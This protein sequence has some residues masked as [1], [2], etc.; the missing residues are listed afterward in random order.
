MTLDEI[1][2][3]FQAAVQSGALGGD[4]PPGLAA[5]LA[6]LGI[7]GPLPL[8][9]GGTG[10][11][12]AEAWLTATT[13]YLRPGWRWRLRLTGSLREDADQADLVLE[14]VFDAGTGPWTFG[15]AFGTLPISRV[16]ADD[17]GG[18]VAG[19]SV[20]AHLV[21]EQPVV[22]ATNSPRAA[23]RLTGTLPLR[24]DAGVPGSDLLSGYADLLGDR[25][26]ADGTVDLPAA[27]PVVLEL[28]ATAPGVG[29][30]IDRPAVDAVGLALTTTF[31]DPAPLHEPHAVLS[32]VLLFA[33]VALPT[34]P[35]DVV[36]V[37]GPLLT[38][39]HLWP[40][41]L[42]FATP[43]GLVGG[44][45]ALT[46]I[47]GGG[48]GDFELPAG[49]AAVDAF[50]L[51]FMELGI[52]PPGR[53]GPGL[54]YVTAGI[55]SDE[56]WDPPVPY[57][58]I[59]R[60]GVGWGFSFGGGGAPFVWG[61]LFGTMTFGRKTAPSLGAAPSYQERAARGLLP[62]AP[63]LPDV[64]VT[65]ELSLPDLWFTAYTEGPIEVGFSQILA[66]LL[67]EA[68]RTGADLTIESLSIEGSLPQKSLG[69]AL[70]VVGDWSLTIGEVILTLAGFGFQVEISQSGVS[71]L[72]RGVGTLTV[73]GADPP[74]PP[75]ELYVEARY[76]GG[77]A[78]V[79]A[80]GARGSV[81]V[82]GLVRG[83]LGRAPDWLRD[84]RYVDVELADLGILFSTASGHPFS[85]SGTL[86]VG[87]P[88]QLLGLAVRLLLSVDIERRLSTASADEH[89]A[90]VA[91]G[92]PAA[93]SG[94]LV[95]GSL[96]G[97]FSVGG[98]VVA[99]SVSVT[100]AEKDFTFAVTYRDVSLRA[101]TSWITSPAPRHEILT[102]TLT[103]TLGELLAYLVALVNPNA[104]FRLDP[105]WDFLGSLDLTGISVV[106]DPTA[107]SVAAVWK[108]KLDLGFVTIESVGV[109]YDH[110]S[111]KPG[112]RIELSARMAGDTVA[113]PR[114][115]DPVNQAPPQ[116]PGLGDRL[117]SLRYLGLGQHVTPAA[118]TTY[119][120]IS[121]VV[122]ALASAMRPVDPVP[123]PP[124]VGAGTPMRFDAS[125]Q[126]L[127]GLDLTVMDTVAVKLVM[128]DPDLY[129]VL[130][131]LSGPQAGPLA[132]LRAEL[133]YRKVADGIGVFH[134]RLQVP[135]ALRHMEFG[136]VSVT[137]GLITVDIY[138]N[139]DFRIDL[140]F[141]SG[142]DFSSSFAVEAGLYNGRGGLYFGVLSGATS[143]RVPAVTDGTFSPVVELGIGLSVGVGRT[144]ERGPLRAG[145]YANLVLI[146]E[147]V[148]AWFH[149]ADGDGDTDLYYWC[150]GTVGIVGR[151]FASVDF[152]II[153][154]EISV[155]VAAMATVELEAYRAAV[156]SLSV[157]LRASAS[158]RIAF[159]TI[160]FSF[161]LSLQ[162]SFTIGADSVPPWHVASGAP[163][164]RLPASVRAEVAP[165][166]GYRLRFDPDARVFP[167]G[168]P[169]TVSLTLVPGYT[170]AG[171]PA[172]WTGQTVPP[173]GDPGY[174]LV[175]TLV[176]DNAVP[177]DAMTI[178]RALRPDVTRNA[179]ADTPADASFN[180]LAE[181]LLRWA[182]D[183]L[184]V[185]G[186]DSVVSLAQLSDLVQQLAMPEAA[187]SGFTW[188]A[189][190][191]FLTA[192]LHL[193]VSGTQ[194]AGGSDPVPGTPFPMLPVLTWT[195]TGLPDPGDA[196]RDFA[197]HQPVD[198]TYEADVLGY[199][200]DL[201]P[202][203]R[204]DA[205]APAARSVAT[206][207][208]SESMATYV[209]RDYFHLVTRAAAQAAVD[210]LTAY[211]YSV[212]GQ[213]SLRSVAA[214]FPAASAALRVA[215]GDT[216]ESV[217]SRLRVTPSE[218]AAH[219]PRLPDELAA[220]R[221]GDGLAVAVAVTPESI[222]LANPDWP[223]TEGSRVNLGDL[224]VQS[225][226]RTLSQLVRDYRL[227][228][229]ADPGYRAA[230]TALTGH[231][232]ATT[233]LLRAGATV[234]VAGLTVRSDAQ[235]DRVAAAFWV[236]LGHVQPLDVPRAD[237]YQQAI[238]RLNPGVPEQVPLDTALDVPTRYEST[239]SS[240][241]APLEGDTLLL[242]AACAAL[243]QEPALDPSFASWL[244][245][246]RAANAP[247]PPGAVVLPAGATAVV[248]PQDTL[249]SLRE[250]LL[251]GPDDFAGY[252]ADADVLLPLVTAEVP[253]AVGE[254]GP[255]LTLLTLGQRYGL[256]LG[257]LAARIAD[258]TGVL[259]PVA[260][261][262]LVVPD[263]PAVPLADLVAAL[264][265]GPAMGSVSGQAARFLLGGLC[266]P[267]PV[268]EGGVYR[269]RG[270]VTGL[271]ELIGQQVT[272][273]P[274]P[275]QP[276]TAAEPP[277]VTV[278]VTKVGPADWL[279]F[280]PP[281]TG[282]A[283]AVGE[284]PSTAVVTVT[285]ADLRDHYPATG[286]Q[287][288]V[289]AP[290]APVPLRHDAAVR[291]PVTQV[292]AWHTTAKVV[293]PAEAAAPPT[294]W[295][296]PA[297]LVARA[298]ADSAGP[299]VLLEQTAPQAA[300]GAPYRELDAY[301]WAALSSFTV[302]RIPGTPGTVEVLGA[303]AAERR[304]IAELLSYLRGSGD[305]AHPLTVAWRLPA[306]PGRTATGLTS[307]PL[308]TDR[309]FVARTN[310]STRTA[311]G[312]AASA[313]TA[314]RN[315]AT[316]GDAEAFLALLWE[317]STVGG[318]GYWM[319]FGG[320]VPDAAFDQDG[321]AEL[322]LVVQ[323]ASQAELR[324]HPFMNAAVVGDGI[325]PATVALTARAAEP[326]P[327]DVR[328]AASA[329][330]G[331][332][333][334]RARFG[335]PLADD[336]PQG[337]LRRLYGLLSFSLGAT[338]AF[339]GSGESRPVSPRPA[340]D[341]DEL[342]LLTACEEAEPVWELSRIVDSGRFARSR[343]PDVPT[344]PPSEGDPY[345]G[346]AARSGIPVLARFGD[347]FGN[348]S[349]TVGTVTLPVRYTDPVV[350]V[351]GWPSTTL[352]YGV[353]AAAD[354]AVLT[355]S[356]DFQAVAYQ[357]GPSGTAAD[358]ATAAATGREQLVSVHHQLAQPDIAVSVLTSLQQAP[359]SD[360]V[361]LAVDADV[362]RRYAIGAHAL[363]DSLTAVLPLPATAAPTLDG[364]CAAYG[365][366]HDALAAANAATPLD[367][368]V[369]A[370]EMAV[371]VTG[372]FHAGETVTAVCARL[373]PPLDA[374][375]VLLDQD[376][377]VLP[378]ATGAELG[379]P[380]H[381]V[382]VPLG[383]P[384][385]G[386][387]AAQCGCS[388]A[389]LVAAN[390]DRA[391]LLTPGFTFEC[392]GLRVGIATDPPQSEATLAGVAL[393]FQQ[394][395]VPFDVQQIVA[396]NS[397]SPG[398]F[399]SGAAVDVDGYL[400]AAGDTLAVNGAGR[401][402]EDLAPLNTTTADL[403][404]P[405]TP[406]FLTVRSAPLTAGET[407]AEFA[408][409]RG[410]T[411]GALLRHNG[412]LTVPPATP[413]VVPGRWQWPE[414]PEE[415]VRVPCTVQPGDSLD[416][417]AGRCPGADLVTVNATMPKTVAP[418]VT[419]TVDG[420]SATTA[421][422]SSF[423]EVCA[424]FDPPADLAALQA[425]IGARTDVLA[426]G[427][428]L[429][430]PPGV[431]PTATPGL[432]GTTPGDAARPFGV[433]AVALLAAN[434][435]APDVLLPGQVL[436][437]PAQPDGSVPTQTTTESDT[438]TAVV[439]RF[440]RQGA[441]VAVET[442]V[443]AN[444]GIGFLRPGA[445]VL[446]PP[447]GARLRV[448]L[449]ES[450]PGA[451]GRP[452]PA[453]VFPV[454]VALDISRDP[455]LVDPD[456]AGSATRNTTAVAPDWAA[457]D[458][459]GTRGLADFAG[460]LRDALPGLWPATGQ[461]SDTDVW[462]VDFGPGA[463]SEVSVRPP[464]ENGQ[465]RVFA[466]RPLATTLFGRSGVPTPELD[467]ATGRLSDTD[468]RDYQ[469]IDMEVWA[470]SL[471]ADVELLLSAAYVRGAHAVAP[472]ALDRIAET[473]RTLAAAVAAGLDRVLDVPD[474]AAGGAAAER[475]AAA[476]TLRQELL[477]SLP[478]GYDTA[479]VIQYDTRVTSPWTGTF[480]RLSGHAVGAAGQDA[481]G[482]SA[483]TVSNGSVSL[484]TGT[485]Q[486][487]FLVSVPDAAAHR[488][489]D[490]SLRFAVVDMEF[491]IAPGADGY[492]RSDW[493]TFTGGPGDLPPQALD[494]VLGDPR[495]PVPLR[496]YPEPPTLLDHQAV[497]PGQVSR[498]E[499]AVR[500][501]YRCAVRHRPAEQDTVELTVTYNQRAAMAA[502]VRSDDLFTALARYDAVSAPLLGLLAGLTVREQ[503]DTAGGEVLARA[504][505]S[506][507]TLA[508]D[509]AVAW[510][511][512]WTSEVPSAVV[513]GPPGDGPVADVYRYELGVLSEDGW[514]TFLSL[515]RSAE[516]GPG[517]VGLPDVVVVA[518]DGERIPLVAAAD[519]AACGCTDTD[520]A[521]LA[522][523]PRTVAASVPVT[524][525]L[526]FPP[527]HIA[528]YQNASARARVTRNARLLGPEGPATREPFVYR[529]PD[530]GYPEPVVPFIDVT[531]V[532][533]L[534][535]WP[536][537]PL[538]P[539]FDTVFDGDPTGRTIAIGMRY[540]HTLVPGDRP[541]TVSL[542]VVQSPAGPYGDATA[543]AI[544]A[545]VDD[546]Q[547]SMRPSPD[548]GAWAVRLS[549]YSSLDPELRRPVLQLR[550][551][552][553]PLADPG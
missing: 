204:Q 413:P 500:W 83:L 409:A 536:S 94:A 75:V 181:G 191:G 525:E 103:G 206:D 319:V 295:R 384:T 534:G 233:P 33:D 156:V 238:V 239:G 271:Y 114:V 535:P 267:A 183:A 250:R 321:L 438:L 305:R 173:N 132:G 66:V 184:G 330:P 439:E 99:A 389:R 142:G 161:S 256:G 43:L 88:E 421:A 1:H 45:T 213:E 149:P 215:T 432:P 167:D 265:D 106:V 157:S 310:L 134:A 135:D 306:A 196:T 508:D 414:R 429:V 111:G 480:A 81:D 322:S 224:P 530:V 95:S 444:L 442:V 283:P 373:D 375:S 28:R 524:F 36:T 294:L 454:T 269:A 347:V 189:V 86:S 69:V 467:L 67:G 291:H 521:C 451:P 446:V 304:R 27:G 542:P 201:D 272:G 47:T 510:S 60:V 408:D 338:E 528:G 163:A 490:L 478:R 465:P 349:A 355:V 392:N 545:A 131:E 428:L 426:P 182:L 63:D 62:P 353:D 423:A 418:G 513:T 41:R 541:V 482:G 504:L 506:F 466:L 218:L 261:R 159:F 259:A 220:A 282:G 402:P 336:T 284:E 474:P 179:L 342:G 264:H 96:S 275:P 496:A 219:N 345:A 105:P 44:I 323:L 344:A 357:P 158:V 170:V 483:A 237:W 461:A 118:L 443:T 257:D 361:A 227:L 440:R 278:T 325:D 203:P 499:D 241:W 14:L 89:L 411:P 359:G 119:T 171:V 39:D 255:G 459:Q 503:E 211:P 365:V 397:D 497:V 356:A 22:R 280:A 495:V 231:L 346:V 102:V 351:G 328:R 268:P 101:A 332:V 216:V 517:D 151:L 489:V 15:E 399:R 108:I 487:S 475:E 37:S 130:V 168:L 434:A 509:V 463:I 488:E 486:V 235:V 320:D 493:L 247:R 3:A 501:R 286:L 390:Q 479:A 57:L 324:L 511:G 226:G 301:A 383:S 236:R 234:P 245:E 292:I 532:L 538:D 202:R 533:P 367:R 109:R 175:I 162:A 276:P 123:G 396:L 539:L 520:C 154:L 49:I 160:S 540:E 70:D 340:D 458:A 546:W 169:R 491:G 470:R 87:V 222:A 552:A 417:L 436:M 85:A 288:V 79:L 177:A 462:A 197:A 104:T 126:W 273:P 100:G 380:R 420:V 73:P 433:T 407:L 18:L 314:G 537:R 121:A 527:V 147:G 117:V 331:R 437:A 50:G 484:T 388:L 249:A 110:A 209:L 20:L 91:L 368:L 113:V 115:W 93:D 71:G 274:P 371:P 453:A 58:L 23:A 403:F 164:R 214:G 53:G 127:L 51:S 8:E 32:A 46:A 370:T 172:D 195:S 80:A 313:A 529:T 165:P 21:L 212:T 369:S 198:A 232:D 205:P 246:V 341:P 422:A 17:G 447:A 82:P 449:R 395:G 262:Q 5:L 514:Y 64:T 377:T 279:S 76:P 385:A 187:G 253:G 372:V 339:R 518:A 468:T 287:P 445:R 464:G 547:Q 548:G 174:R 19:E 248:Q 16:P 52:T 48:S 354:G 281:A 473:K 329:D 290:L 378:L 553:S 544:V 441:A 425:A 381:Q 137:L 98:L 207:G 30:G 469:G 24:G 398:M 150:R 258:D 415:T 406:L 54:S 65:V 335:N 139:G 299:R 56:P 6:S 457:A 61:T 277:V 303:D 505:D 72:L 260:G 374:V 141:P 300:S 242:V 523:P 507:A 309:T 362:L 427:A 502:S 230:L 334:F 531:G 185:G 190:T 78:W 472:A 326:G 166:A 298:A 146:V 391:G 549:L 188:Q 400:V 90:V 360:P 193:V 494:I 492:E 112:V 394:N 455:T 333:G 289:V 136:P 424:M 68:P 25:L 7:A 4:S 308:D 266:L 148:L 416:A 221:P 430:C 312:R 263:V 2:A 410:C 10:I 38:G 519:P 31:P 186:S 243:L 26:Q 485:S 42:D 133:L 302:R 386:D 9:A 252:V 343:L 192:N 143:S 358:T 551:L 352:R 431:V 144:F 228:A 77:G 337:R 194:G 379:V 401:P 153:G 74:A 382:L 210:L 498:V 270:P 317:C 125:S 240:S 318:G 526:T 55:E 512:H 155:Q 251:A 29:L 327:L 522:F 120:G 84:P 176:T 348:P 124:P 11:G 543:P 40:V 92:T 116:A 405:G 225:G 223:V 476:S 435:G 199:F 122:D 456:L 217:A 208:G 387:V 404:P 460:R 140:G 97:T 180:L 471:L 13:T 285:G 364:I 376:N 366:D 12:S 315:S 145:L 152:K 59:D 254:T 481:P 129:G 34:T 311:A 307:A 448:H 419:V 35:A 412:S 244:G 515:V 200:A 297:D 350:G 107:Q 393:L 450:L 477:V 452:F 550:H 178:A 516:A 229:P 316:L 293:L 296:L 138:T 128:H 363:L